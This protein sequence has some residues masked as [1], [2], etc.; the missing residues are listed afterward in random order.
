MR[1]AHA[2]AV[3]R[4]RL[5]GSAR[6][7]LSLRPFG[8]LSMARDAIGRAPHRT[9]NV[10]EAWGVYPLDDR[11]VDTMGSVGRHID[12]NRY[13]RI[14]EIAAATGIFSLHGRVRTNENRLTPHQLRRMHVMG[15][16]C[17]LRSRA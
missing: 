11:I 12:R 3:S 13:Q 16:W 15:F 5:S 9:R 4:G 7:P 10:T 8:G 1:P 17:S 2:G 6:G 14:M